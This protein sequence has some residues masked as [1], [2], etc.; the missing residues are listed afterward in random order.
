MTINEPQSM[1]SR[2]SVIV[3]EESKGTCCNI[4]RKLN[5]RVISKFAIVC[6]PLKWLHVMITERRVLMPCNLQCNKHPIFATCNARKCCVASCKKSRTRSS[7]VHKVARQVAEC[8][9]TQSELA[10][11][12]REI[13]S[14]RPEK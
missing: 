14:W 10:F 13:S 1:D 4:A 11:C 6:P 2:I 3:H 12:S 8:A 7:T 9:L 5:L